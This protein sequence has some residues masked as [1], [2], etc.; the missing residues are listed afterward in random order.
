MRQGLAAVV[1]L[2]VLGAGVSGCYSKVTA[3]EGKF[4]LAYATAVQ[5]EN[6]VKPIA[7]GAKLDVVVFTNGTVKKMKVQSAKSSRPNVLAVESAADEKIVL[8]GVA[9]GVAVLEVTA[10]DAEG[11]ALTDRMFFHV[12]KPAKHSLEHSCTEDP[13]AAY[14]KGEDID[15]LH[16]LSTSDDRAVVGYEYAPLKAEPSGALELVAQP[17]AWAFY[18]YKSTSARPK[19]TLRS[20]IDGKALTMRIVD[21]ADLKDAVLYSSDRMIEGR[22]DWVVAHVSL[23]STALC[24]QNA[25][26]KAKSLTPDICTISANLDEEPDKDSNREQLA[27]V[28]ALK[29]GECKYQVILP[30]LAGGKGIV[31]EGTAK[32]GR[33]EF[34]GEKR[35]DAPGA[36]PQWR[37]FGYDRDAWSRAGWWLLA[38]R[39]AALAFVIGWL[40]GRSTAKGSSASNSSA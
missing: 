15:I 2:G 8:K 24:N 37:L 36:P 27:T 31:L 6:F 29:F 19:V 38:S 18:R 32:V 5:Y 20:D 39:V 14:V 25:L 22:T 16:N 33:I 35:A 34:P 17:Q 28:K 13:D 40:R 21:R 30:E 4:T 10:T 12:A 1:L 3:H 7:P 11:K 26:T 23:G 9:A